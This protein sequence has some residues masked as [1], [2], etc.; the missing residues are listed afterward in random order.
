M[1]DVHVLIADITGSTRLYEAVHQTMA[2]RHV[3]TVLD[4]MREI[5]ESHGG[6]FVK[7]QGDDT[8]SVM[9]SGDD[10]LA[11][12]HHMITRDWPYG[13]GIHAGAARGEVLHHGDDIYGDAVNTAA[14][15]A[16]MAKPGEVLMDAATFDTLTTPV[17][18]Q[19]VALGNLPLKGKRDSTP[20][21]SYAPGDAGAQTVVAGATG[22]GA[23]FAAGAVRIETGGQ[24]WTLRDGERLL[25]G[26]SEGCDIVLPHPWVSRK[27]GRFE[28]RAGQVEY[29]DHSSAGSV[30]LWADGTEARLHR[31]TASLDRAGMLLCG[32]ADAEEA[33]S[34]V[35]FGPETAPED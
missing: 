34:R 15:L 28:M 7:S 23:L 13:L 22:R 14:R 18:H 5:I 31:K 3:R 4:G 20:V 24:R 27:H 16:T 12:A 33:G 19:C 1:T 10:T 2:L 6:T 30:I 9:A 8:F 11:V 35:T 25:L 17:R 26:R 21:H 32:T 29:S